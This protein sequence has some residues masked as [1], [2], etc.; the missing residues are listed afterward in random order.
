MRSNFWNFDFL[1]ERQNSFFRISH[2]CQTI[3]SRPIHGEDGSPPQPNDGGSALPPQP[4]QSV[5]R[6]LTSETFYE[7]S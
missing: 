6:F 3:M 1:R 2:A 4:L 5:H 7:T